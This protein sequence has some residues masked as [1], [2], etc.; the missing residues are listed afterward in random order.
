MVDEHE[1]DVTT[2]TSGRRPPG[3]FFPARKVLQHRLRADPAP[4]GP[5]VATSPLG[6]RQ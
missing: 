5:S 6:V 2:A 3:R 1:S 4:T